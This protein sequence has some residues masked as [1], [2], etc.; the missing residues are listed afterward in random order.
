[1]QCPAYPDRG[2]DC[3]KITGTKCG[4]GL[5][6]KKTLAEKISHCRTCDF[7]RLHAHKI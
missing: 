2:E 6:E 7:F 5:M 4:K 1:M 3:W